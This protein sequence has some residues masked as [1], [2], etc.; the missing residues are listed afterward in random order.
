[1]QRLILSPKKLADRLHLKEDFNVLEIDSGSGYFSV[2]VARCIPQGH[3]ELFDLQKRC[4]KK[5]VI[6]LSQ[7]PKVIRSIIY[8]RTARRP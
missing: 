6:R 7:H 5:H 1:M 2:E 8:H 4:L 3:L